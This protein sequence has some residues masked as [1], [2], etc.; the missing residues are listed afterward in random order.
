MY[1]N[2]YNKM[3]WIASFDIGKKNFAFYIQEF[4][5]TQ[6][7]QIKNIPKDSRYNTEGTCKEPFKNT[8]EQVYKNGKNK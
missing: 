6:L 7:S 5:P 3:I 2:T 1:Y 4:D 8:M